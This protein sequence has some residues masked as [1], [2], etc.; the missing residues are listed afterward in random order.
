M[1]NLTVKIDVDDTSAAG[2]ALKKGF[3]IGLEES[4]EY[5]MNKGE[6][7]AKERVMSADR[8]WRR[9]LKKGF[10]TNENQFS[11]WDHWQGEIRN[12][13]PHAKLN[14]DGM[15][16][17][18]SPSVQDILPW[19]DDEMTAGLPS[20]PTHNYNPE[21]W[22]PD[23]KRAAAEYGAHK[24]ITAFAVKEGLEE[25]GYPGIGFMETT[26]KYLQSLAIIVKAKVEKEMN[27]KMREAG[28][29]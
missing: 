24:V 28:F 23:L 3:R 20:V 17:G 29:Q 26:E 13:A 8:V 6:E 22:H 16:P 5:L 1:G 7:H 14:E 25:S 4:G 19:V 21:N 11:R 12:D 15:P 18:F 10:S 2:P 9:T 27:R